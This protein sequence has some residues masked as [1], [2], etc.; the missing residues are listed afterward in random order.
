MKKSQLRKLIRRVIIENKKDVRSKRALLES[1]QQKIDKWVKKLGPGDHSKFEQVL[2]AV[3]G[4]DKSGGPD[5]KLGGVGSTGTSRRGDGGGI[6]ATPHKGDFIQ[7]G[8][9]PEELWFS[10]DNA[11]GIIPE[12][13][14]TM[15]LIGANLNQDPNVH[16]SDGGMCLTDCSGGP[17]QIDE[18]SPDDQLIFPSTLTVGSLNEQYPSTITVGGEAFN[19]GIGPE[20]INMTNWGS[21]EPIGEVI[22]NFLQWFGGLPTGVQFGIITVLGLYISEWTD[23]DGNWHGFGPDGIWSQIYHGIKDF[24]I[25]IFGGQHAPTEDELFGP[26]GIDGDG[27]EQVDPTDPDNIFDTIPDTTPDWMYDD[28]VYA[29][30]DCGDEFYWDIGDYDTGDWEG[31]VSVGDF[32]FGSVDIDWGEVLYNGEPWTPDSGGDFGGAS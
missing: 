28:G 31:D 22:G 16:I 19:Y 17:D 24:I 32:D 1:A 5:A 2:Q 15:L 26:D 8:G 10:L 30:A 6:K 18:R 21:L 23:G 29:C 7:P 11:E 25:D 27:I 14:N 3:L 12:V 20:G 13:Y 4:G 9:E